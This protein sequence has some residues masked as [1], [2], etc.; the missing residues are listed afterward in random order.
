MIYPHDFEYSSSSYRLK[1]WHASL[2]KLIPSQTANSKTD[3]LNVNALGVN[4]RRLRALQMIGLVDTNTTSVAARPPVFLMIVNQCK[5]YCSTS[6]IHGMKY[7]VDPDLR[8]FE[9]WIW[10]V[11]TSDAA[12]SWLTRFQLIFFFSV[13]VSI[14]WA[15]IILIAAMGVVTVTYLIQVRFLH[16]PLATVVESTIYPVYEIPFP[17]VTICN[18]NRLDWNR[19]DEVIELYGANVDFVKVKY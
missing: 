5:R 12:R 9:R 18:Y 19:V 13:L 16:S 10:I 6:S 17:A 14:I 1:P 15:L 11:R 3:S 7:L 4:E 2:N 8:W